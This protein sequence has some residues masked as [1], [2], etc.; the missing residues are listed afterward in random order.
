[1]DGAALD[2]FPSLPLPALDGPPRDLSRAGRPTLIVLGHGDCRTTRLL[3]AFVERIERRRG[4]E[5]DVVVVLQDTPEDARALVGDLGL[6]MPVLL[7]P[8]PWALGTALRT[9]VVPLTML[10]EPGG[11]VAEAWPAFRRADLERAAERF[12]AAPL[13][14][15]GEDVPALR[16]G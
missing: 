1:M 15:P 9:E 13:F 4:P 11:A 10:V 7:D 12:G 14:D 16:P 3:L 6:T 5:R 8:E 2:A